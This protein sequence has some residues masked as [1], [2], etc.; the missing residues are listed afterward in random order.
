MKKIFLLLVFMLLIGCTLGNTPTA[1]VEDYLSRHQMLDKDISVSYTNLTS[2]IGLD[3]DIISRYEDVIEKQYRNLSY[4]IKDEEIDGNNAI[5]TIQLEVM[6]YKKA[7]DMFNKSEYE[8][9]RYHELVLDEL[10]KT[11]EMITYTIDFNVTKEKDG[12]WKVNDLSNEDRR[13]LLGIN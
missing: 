1:R 13:K 7:I 3:E 11:K 8:N 2:D 12:M 5:V 10:E 4:E 9:S 6:N